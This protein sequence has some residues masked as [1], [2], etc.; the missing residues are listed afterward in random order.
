MP[1]LTEAQ[2]T[3]KAAIA[4]VLKKRT[5]SQILTETAIRGA[6]EH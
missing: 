3:Q 5:V 4:T 2:V 1:L 6:R